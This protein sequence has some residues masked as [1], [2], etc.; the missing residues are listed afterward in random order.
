M[1]Y[2]CVYVCVCV[3]TC[4]CKDIYFKDLAH[5]IWGAGKFAICKAGWQDGG[6]GKC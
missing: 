1:V 5:M 6:P 4:V 2:V 3:R